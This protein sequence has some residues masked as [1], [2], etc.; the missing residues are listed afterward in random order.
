MWALLTF[1]DNEH[2]IEFFESKEKAIDAFVAWVYE[3]KKQRGLMLTQY[4]V[5]EIAYGYV[6]SSG[7]HPEDYLEAKLVQVE[8]GKKYS[9]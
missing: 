8:S 6:Q 7:A 4:V 3:M 2:T 9:Y 5:R 1:V